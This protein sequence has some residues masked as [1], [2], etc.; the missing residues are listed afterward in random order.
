MSMNENKKCP[1]TARDIIKFEDLTLSPFNTGSVFICEI[2]V[3][4]IIK[5]K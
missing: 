2:L 5:S 4:M 3:Q 1:V